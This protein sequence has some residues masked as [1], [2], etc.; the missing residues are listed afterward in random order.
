MA[1]MQNQSPTTPAPSPT[2]GPTPSP[3]APSRPT[4]SPPP[5]QKPMAPS[6]PSSPKGGANTGANTGAGRPASGAPKGT[7]RAINTSMTPLGK[8]KF[9]PEEARHLLWRAGF[10]GSPD[11]VSLLAKWG[12]DRSVDYLVNYDKSSPAPAEPETNGEIMKGMSATERDEY[13][14]AL[15]ARDE[16]TLARFRLMRQ[17]QEQQDREQMRQMQNWW[18]TRMIETPR[19]LEEKMT[20]FW[21][22]H[23][24]TSYRTIENSMHM[25]MQNAM[26]R[27]NAVGNF[28]ELLFNI[29]RDPAILKY[30]NN[31]TSRKGKPNENLAREL[32]ELFSLGVGA[33]TERDIKEGARALTGFTFRN[34][35]FVFEK[36]NHDTGVKSILGSEGAM[37]GDAFVRAILE[38]P[39]CATFLCTKLFRWFVGEYP[40]GRRAFD[41]AG[42][43]IIRQMATTLGQ[44]RYELK[45]VLTQ[46]FKSQAF[47][48]PAFRVEQIKSPVQL[49]VGAVRGLK[50]PVRD[51]AV[52]VDA[53]DRMGQEVFLPPSVKGWD[54]GRAWINTATMFVR[55]NL[56][57]FL[58]TG[59]RPQGRDGLADQERWDPT[60]LLAQLADLSRGDTLDGLL[61]FTLGRTNPAGRPQLEAFLASRGGD[62]ALD[63]ETLTQLMLLITAMPEYQLC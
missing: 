8:D 18:V 61:W 60:P 11:Q 19:P 1:W 10:G 39:A 15:Q 2:T 57:V 26:F 54:G 27:K 20:L 62:K 50:T 30:L 3:G 16:D 33:Y 59:R 42:E 5:G 44:N 53:M 9:G 55:Q 24:A 56:L 35:R 45:P 46:L 40:T 48:D 38:Q 43:S 17:Q 6:S 22:G 31:D 34:D 36:N 63:R 51:L 58:L 47:Y 29:I 7:S 4:L 13:R 32:M 23:F 28:G 49:V 37:D 25:V 41:Q 21:H 14:R 52:L 12:L